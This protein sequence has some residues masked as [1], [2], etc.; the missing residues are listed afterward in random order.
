VEVSLLGRSFEI[1]ALDAVGWLRILTAKNLDLYDIFPVMA[2]QDAIELVEDALW[3]HLATDEEITRIA[4]DVISTVADRPWWVVLRILASV[5]DV[6][7]RLHVNNAAGMSFAGWLD[8][9]WAKI[10]NLMDPKRVTSW[11]ASVEAPPKG[12][13]TEVDFD[14]EERAFMAAM[15]SAM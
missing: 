13:E 8:E 15:R 6:W 7:D 12:W 2:G 1:P 11:V 9:V 10:M 5:P 14:A 4:W 3:D